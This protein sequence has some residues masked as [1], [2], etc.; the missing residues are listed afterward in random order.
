[1]KESSSEHYVIDTC[2]LF[3]FYF[4]LQKFGLLRSLFSRKI[5]VVP[6][7]LEE[8]RRLLTKQKCR[9]TDLSQKL[10][11][12]EV[13][14]VDICDEKI[15]EFIIA[16]KDKLGTGE[17]FSAALALQKGWI[18]L[19]DDWVAQQILMFGHIG[20]QCKSADWILNL[21]RKKRLIGS[22]EYK[23]L[24]SQLSKAKKR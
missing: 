8:F 24:L 18:L 1:L 5:H 4:D 20:L 21:A 16:F 2:T 14:E 17:R 3:Y 12:L 11:F 23:K 19:T 15:Q 22:V 10:N 7:V 6:S 13:N 9:I